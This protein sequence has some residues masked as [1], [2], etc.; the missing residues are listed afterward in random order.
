MPKRK[1]KPAASLT[2]TDDFDE[3]EQ[4]ESS[5]AIR[6]K[7]VR[8]VGRSTTDASERETNEGDTSDEEDETEVLDDKVYLAALCSHGSI[9]CAYFEPMKKVL[10]LLEDTR[11]TSH[12][13]LTRML[14]EQVNPHLILTS[15]KADDH[16]IDELFDYA[17]GAD[18]TFQIRPFKEFVAAKGRDRLLSLE[19]FSSIVTVPDNEDPF[20]PPGDTSNISRRGN[21]YDFMRSRRE[22]TGGDPTVKRWN[23]SIRLANFA[24]VEAS[25]LCMASVGAL[26]DYMVKERALSDFDDDGI[27]GLDIRNIETLA[28]DQVMQINQDALISLQIFEN[29]S[30]AS[31]HSDKTKEGLSLYVI[32]ARHDAVECFSLPENISTVNSLQNHLKGIKNLPR[33]M[34]LMKEGKGKITDWQ[35]LVKFTYHAT[36]LRG[37][38]SELHQASGVTIVKKLIDVLDISAF[39]EIGSKINDMIDWEESA[40][41]GRECVR[42]NIDEDLDNRKHVYHGIDSL[43]STVAQEISRSVPSGYATSL[44]VV[45]FPQL[46]YL[47]CTP[48][49]EEWRTEAGIQPLDGW[50]FQFSSDSYV[51]FKSQEMHDMDTHIGD[52]HSTIVDR[53]LEIIQELLEEVLLCDDLVSSACDVCAELDCL[54]SF[55][56]ATRVYDYTRPEMVDENMIEII[57]GR[58]PLQERVVDAFVPNDARLLGGAGLG[59]T[60]DYPN[61][62]YQWNSVMLCTGANACGKSVFLKQIAVIQIMAQIGWFVYVFS[63]KLHI[64]QRLI[65]DTSFVSAE[66]ARLGIVDKIFTRVSTRESVS[67]GQSAFMIDLSQVSQLLRNN[68]AGLFCGVLRHLINRGPDCPKVVVATHFH[69]VFNEELLD[70]ERAPISFRHMQVMFTTTSGARVEPK[71]VDTS[72]SRAATPASGTVGDGSNANIGPTDKITYLYRVAEGLSLDS[73]AAKCAEIFGI[74]PRFVERA[75]YVSRLLSSHRLNVLLDEGMTDGETADLADAEAV[76]RRFLSWDLKQDEEEDLTSGQVKSKLAAVLG[77]CKDNNDSTDR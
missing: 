35:N 41:N 25:P 11:E 33:T 29:E 73:H 60:P 46:G 20:G 57:Q 30:H 53:E 62:L 16:F 61:A 34:N 66:S 56:E 4:D 24:S 21:A 59:A 50:T 13:D 45:Y 2:R 1:L 74:P 65:S 54:L 39:K 17:D 14:L 43:L 8:W 7:K 77:I 70:P 55:A 58:H 72:M 32:E 75:Q 5:P 26:L 9:G 38:L 15:S 31:V 63:S 27:S 10:Y 52:L 76:C 19:H 71:S 40:L 36:M 51:Y 6:K 64:L 3:P 49:L 18:G 44:N 12:F 69:D 42:P 22:A 47:I 28:L 23:A 68:G 67:K 37:S 48:M